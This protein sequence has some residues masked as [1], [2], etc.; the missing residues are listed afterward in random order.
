MDFVF[1]PVMLGVALL[2]ALVDDGGNDAASPAQE[3]VVDDEPPA[4][5]DTTPVLANDQVSYTGNN[6]A[7]TVTGNALANDI[8][9]KGNN[10]KILG[11]AGNDTLLGDA[12]IDILSGNSDDDEI[13]GG[14]W[15]DAIGGGAGNDNLNGDNGSDTIFGGSGYDE[16]DGGSQSDLLVGELGDD[17]LVGGSGA[18]I[19]IGGTW[20]LPLADDQAKEDAFGEYRLSVQENGGENANPLIRTADFSN[21]SQSGDGS[22]VLI[23]GDGNDA[24]FLGNHDTGVGGRGDDIFVVLEGGSGSALIKDFNFGKDKLFIQYFEVLNPLGPPEVEIRNA[25]PDAIVLV[26]GD[27]VARMEDGAGKVAASDLGLFAISS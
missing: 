24:L 21:I 10:D 14:A 20:D 8:D 22:D 3:D 23:G 25:G 2:L 4:G 1:L 13:Y 27:I 26:D 12:G 11:K 5:P 7:E 6:F 18:D 19:L 9:A 15:D 16:I 17:T